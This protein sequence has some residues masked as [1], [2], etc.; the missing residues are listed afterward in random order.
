LK[1]TPAGIDGSYLIS[2]DAYEDRRGSFLELYHASRYAEHGIDCHFVQDNRSISEKGVLRGL[3]YQVVHPI[4]HIVYVAQG[5]ILDVGLDLRPNSPTFKQ[6]ISVELSAENHLQLF[7]PPGVAHGFYTFDERNEILYKCTEFY[8]PD[9][10][11][12]VLWNDPD[13]CIDWPTSEPRIKSRDAMFPCL[14]DIPSSKL[15]KV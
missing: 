2:L 6:H 14:C 10:E 9:D 13:L 12:G 8:Y 4:G 5:R 3:H 1:V 15:P 7:L 11:A